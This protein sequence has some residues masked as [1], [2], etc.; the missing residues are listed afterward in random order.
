[1][2][3]QGVIDAAYATHPHLAKGT[4][5]SLMD[6]LEIEPRT[7]RNSRIASIHLLLEVSR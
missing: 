5:P 6:T 4:S 3:E 7:T 2:P 1:M